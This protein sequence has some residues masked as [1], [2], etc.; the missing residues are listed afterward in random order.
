MQAPIDKKG[1]NFFLNQNSHEPVTEPN[2]INIY[3][4]TSIALLTPNLQKKK[5]APPWPDFLLLA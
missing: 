5:G 2:A 4:I 3:L 1:A